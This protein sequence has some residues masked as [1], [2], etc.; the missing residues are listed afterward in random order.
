MSNAGSPATTNLRLSVNAVADVGDIDVGAVSGPPIAPL[1]VGD[2][3]RQRRAL[4]FEIYSLPPG[5]PCPVC[6][7]AINKAFLLWSFIV[8]SQQPSGAAVVVWVSV[9]PP[10]VCFCRFCSR[11]LGR[12]GEEVWP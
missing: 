6:E 10:A 7:T 3:V 8:L 4:K 9:H 1:Y 12:F 2:Q 11:C 5:L